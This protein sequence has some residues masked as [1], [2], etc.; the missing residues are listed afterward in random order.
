MK[1]LSRLNI[2]ESVSITD[3]KPGWQRVGEDVLKECFKQ[4]AKNPPEYQL[5]PTSLFLNR[6]AVFH[7]SGYIEKHTVGYKKLNLDCSNSSNSSHIYIKTDW[8]KV[9]V[10]TK[11]LKINGQ[12]YKFKN[13]ITVD[14]YSVYIPDFSKS[15]EKP[16]IAMIGYLNI[17]DLGKCSLQI[18]MPLPASSLKNVKPEEIIKLFK[19]TVG[20]DLEIL[21]CSYDKKK[22]LLKTSC[23][24]T[25]K[26]YGDSYT[27]TY[28]T[29]WTQPVS[30][31]ADYFAYK[32]DTPPGEKYYKEL[33]NNFRNAFENFT[34]LK[35]SDSKLRE[36]LPDI[37]ME[38]IIE[39]D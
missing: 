18:E 26:A 27:K 4:W 34:G 39:F 30:G 9:Q 8:K 6:E 22:N 20:Q 17:P 3:F 36:A 10:S 25:R 28:N 5:A 14:H 23:L 24:T 33:L 21:S 13:E 19:K 7:S 35:Y 32:G 11:D 37:Q 31:Y 29:L 12:I 38:L 2:V 16:F 15:W 1:I